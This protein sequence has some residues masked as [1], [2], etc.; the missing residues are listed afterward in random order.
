LPAAADS[1]SAWVNWITRR[2]HSAVVEHILTA[3]AH[4]VQ[5]Y[6]ACLGILRLSRP[7]AAREADP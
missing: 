6:R 2:P 4:P 3:R 5:G 1:H 7:D